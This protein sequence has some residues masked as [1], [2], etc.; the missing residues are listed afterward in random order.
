MLHAHSF[1]YHRHGKMFF[2]QYFS[3]SCHYLSTVAPYSFIHLP[4]TL[5]NFS[6]WQRTLIS[7][8]QGKW[9]SQRMML[10]THY[11][12]VRMLRMNGAMPQ[13]P[14]Y[15]LKASQGQITL[16]RFLISV[17]RHMVGETSVDYVVMGCRSDRC[18]WWESLDSVRCLSQRALYI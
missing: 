7:E 18:W 13:L 4:P 3:F 5:Y 2:F 10:T 12:V 8:R 9:E 15:T 16:H 14:H 1:I 11:H 17:G 6:S